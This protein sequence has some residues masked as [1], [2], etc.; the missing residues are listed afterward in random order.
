M[1]TQ[2][3]VLSDFGLFVRQVVGT[4]D[5]QISVFNLSAPQTPYKQIP[6]PLKFQTRCVTCFPDTAGYLVGSIEVRATPLIFGGTQFASTNEITNAK[7]SDRS[8]PDALHG[9][10]VCFPDTAGCLV[11][12]IEVLMALHSCQERSGTG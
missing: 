8:S 10:G 4:A 9:R 5:R 11:G 1:L 2:L 12:S 6:S 7:H 3:L